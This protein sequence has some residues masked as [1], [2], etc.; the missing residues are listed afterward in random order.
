MA[1]KMIEG[2]AASDGMMVTALTRAALRSHSLVP[3]V[4]ASTS[5]T[6]WPDAEVERGPVTPRPRCVVGGE[7]ASS[8]A[9]PVLHTPETVRQACRQ[10]ALDRP[11]TEFRKFLGRIAARFCSAAA[12]PCS[13]PP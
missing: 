4:L 2:S 5:R 10:P 7:E 13:C 6:T 9:I 12:T 8:R 3:H 11:L 1:R